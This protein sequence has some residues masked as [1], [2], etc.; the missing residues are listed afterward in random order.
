MIFRDR[1]DAGRQL[2]EKLATLRGEPN[3]IV[4]GIPRGGVVVAAEIAQELDAPLDVL[5]AHKIGL[6]ENPEFAVGAVTSTGEV[7]LD[8]ET[9]D[10]LR[11]DRA[12]IARAV[13][14][15]R[16]EVA[17]RVAIF[18][19]GRAALDVKEKIAIV[20]DDGIATGSTMFA[21]VQAL[22]KQQPTQ[23]IV[24]VPVGPGETIS[25][26]RAECDQVVVLETPIP[27]W[28]VGRF[29]V[30]FEQTEDAQVIKLLNEAQRRLSARV[31]D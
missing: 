27:F 16:E 30:R 21:A 12:E 4:L 26:L 14:Q 1:K 9:L 13:E 8:E 15:W 5:I 3:L 7:Y 6:P 25:R 19:G 10:E 22:K 31:E 20:V 24:A 28:A 23:L 18:R 29:Y 11:I 2:A 17:H